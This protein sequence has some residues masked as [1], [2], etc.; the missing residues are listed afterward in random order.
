MRTASSA[1]ATCGACASASEWTA[2]VAIP[3]RRAVRITRQ[4]ISPRLAIRSLA[5]ISGSR[6]PPLARVL[7]QLREAEEQQQ[8]A[9]HDLY[10]RHHPRRLARRHDVAVAHRGHGH[11]REVE[12]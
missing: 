1:I 10:P 12:A 9:E 5:N 6:P 8:H 4:A 11:Q 3:I 7:H 2:T